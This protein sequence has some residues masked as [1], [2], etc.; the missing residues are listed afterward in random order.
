MV[1]GRHMQT[2]GCQIPRIPYSRA[3]GITHQYDLS[4]SA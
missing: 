1:A 4:D 3:T 2:G